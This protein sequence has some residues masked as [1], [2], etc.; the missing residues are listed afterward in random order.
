M[1]ATPTKSSLWRFV[2]Y[3]WPPSLAHYEAEQLARAM[4]RRSYRKASPYWKP[5]DDTVGVISQIDNMHAGVAQEL[6]EVR[7]K[8][9]QLIYAVASKHDNET[10]HETALRYILER[11]SPRAECPFCGASRASQKR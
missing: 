3:W 9:D 8:Y 4:W 6:E 2:R 5:L 1:K 11:E 7:M 10:R